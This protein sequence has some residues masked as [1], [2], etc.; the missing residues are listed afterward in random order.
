DAPGGGKVVHLETAS[1]EKKTGDDAFDRTI[2]PAE[3]AA[4]KPIPRAPNHESM[5]IIGSGPAG[6]TAAIYGARALLNP[7][8]SKG[9]QW[10][11]QLTTTSEVENYPGFDQGVDGTELTDKM[12]KQAQRF[13]ARTIPETIT[14]VDFTTMPFQIWQGD[15]RY[16]AD[17]VVISTGA[18]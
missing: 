14:R 6:Y 13:G 4:R 15:Q 3:R 17:A 8:L 5:V 16:T 12:E 1:G 2:P 7:L 9:A 10:G 18:S 11:G